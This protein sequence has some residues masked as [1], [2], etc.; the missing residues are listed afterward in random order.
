MN[1]SDL[2]LK[3][4]AA[5]IIVQYIDMPTTKGIF[6][7]NRTTNQSTF[8]FSFLWDKKYDTKNNIHECM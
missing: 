1:A 4:S 2:N 8:N 3:R 7:Q 6:L 5:F